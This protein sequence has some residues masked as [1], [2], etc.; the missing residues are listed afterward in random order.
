M[1]LY[2]SEMINL[3]NK[4]SIYINEPLKQDELGNIFFKDELIGKIISDDIFHLYKKD[5]SKVNNI[6]NEKL[7]YSF[8]KLLPESTI[9]CHCFKKDVF[10]EPKIFINKIFERKEKV[11]K[12]KKVKEK[13]EKVVIRNNF[14][15]R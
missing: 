8:K 6:I 14:F 7:Y 3:N 15:F 1:V 11:L 13:E 4:I 5:K 9:I 2:L 10:E 12:I